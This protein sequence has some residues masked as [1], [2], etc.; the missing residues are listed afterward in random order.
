MG[1]CSRSNFSLSISAFGMDM[2]NGVRFAEEAT[3]KG[4]VLN[5]METIVEAVCSSFS[6]ATQ[7]HFC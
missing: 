5:G 6:C 2:L 3:G 1:E 4:S 7:I